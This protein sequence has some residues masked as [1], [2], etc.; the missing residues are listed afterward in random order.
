VIEIVAKINMT[1]FIPIVTYQAIPA[2][3]K[4]VQT[5]AIKSRNFD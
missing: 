4:A 2:K 1:T 5:H 3:T